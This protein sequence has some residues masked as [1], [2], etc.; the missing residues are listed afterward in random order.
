MSLCECV[1]AH[2]RV[3]QLPLLLQTP[4]MLCGVFVF[5]CVCV[6]ERDF[7]VCVCVVCAL[8]GVCCRCVS[9]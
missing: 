8:L 3:L 4:V 2:D 1:C 5:M 7:G 6:S 9:V